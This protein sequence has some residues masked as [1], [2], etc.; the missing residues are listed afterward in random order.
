MAEPHH[1]D[2]S[3]DINFIWA[4]VQACPDEGVQRYRRSPVRDPR[5]HH[6]SCGSWVHEKEEQALRHQAAEQVRPLQCHGRCKPCPCHR[7]RTQRIKDEW[8]DYLW[9]VVREEDLAPRILPLEAC[10]WHIL[11][12]EWECS[13]HGLSGARCKLCIA[14]PLLC[15]PRVS[16]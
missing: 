6:E 4:R 5:C 9:L 12:R 15:C 3:S 13:Q 11:F 2:C 16:R 7:G 1:Q 10:R 8:Q 14:P